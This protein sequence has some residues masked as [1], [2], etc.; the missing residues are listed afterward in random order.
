MSRPWMNKTTNA[1]ANRCLPLRIACAHGWEVLN[2][3]RFAAIWKGGDSSDQV[4]IQS[5]HA[6]SHWV[7]SHF[8]YGTITFQMHFLVQTPHGVHLHVG[9]P[10]NEPKDGIV[11]L[12]GVIETDWAHMTFTMNWKFTRPM[13]PVIFEKDEPICQFFPLLRAEAVDAMGLEIESLGDYPELDAK[14]REWSA[15]R[16]QLHRDIREG[17]KDSNEW[18]GDYLRGA[19]RKNVKLSSPTLRK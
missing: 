15:S 8:G 4:L 12:A 6:I 13:E 1:F 11:P 2:P 18:Q 9:G 7:A 17:R 3:F 14:Y 5:D 16:E 10:A 19:R